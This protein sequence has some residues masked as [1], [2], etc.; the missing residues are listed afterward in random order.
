MWPL[1]DI[2]FDSRE[3]KAFSLFVAI[4]GTR[5]NGFEFIEQAIEKGATAIVAEQLPET[6]QNHVTYVRV[7]DA[8]EAL[9]K[10]AS[11]F[12]DDPSET[13]KIVAVTGTKR[14]NYHG[15]FTPPVV[16]FHGPPSWNAL[17]R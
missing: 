7:Q 12:F 15:E 6:T 14:Q 4:P 17:N 9:G 11:T 13:L 2:A 10:M 1:R 8:A 3:V 5:V 16:P